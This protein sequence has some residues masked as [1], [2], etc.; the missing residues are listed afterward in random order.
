MTPLLLAISRNMVE[1]TKK[2]IFSGVNTNVEDS[3]RNTAL[4]Y[5]CKKM[6]ISYLCYFS[7]DDNVHVDILEIGKLLIDRGVDVL[8]LNHV[9]KR[10]S[11]LFK[12]FQYNNQLYLLIIDAE[13][14]AHNAHKNHG[15]LRAVID[16]D[17]I[18]NS[19]T[20]DDN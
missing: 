1:L 13:I 20:D 16:Y 11:D 6:N 10:A 7:T 2:L 19:D 9:G 12:P 5:L 4:H 18:V 3:M 14:N 8:A 17:T 15:F